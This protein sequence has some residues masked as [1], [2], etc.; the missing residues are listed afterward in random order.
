MW[1]TIQGHDH[2][3]DRFRLAAM[4]GRLSGT[5]LLVGP[6]GVGKRSMAVQL[7]K[8]ILCLQQD[9]EQSLNACNACES[10]RLLDSGNHPD[11]HT[12]TK[13]NDRQLVTIDL[14]VGDQNHRNREGLLV[15]MAYKPALSSRKIAMIDDADLFNIESANTLLKTLEEPPPGAIIFLIGTSQNRQ[16]PT[17]R[18]RSQVIRFGRLAD[19]LVADLL[20]SKG[21][22]SDPTRAKELASA[23]YGSISRAIQLADEELW[24]FRAHL[25]QCLVAPGIDRLRVAR[26]AAKFVDGAGTETY[27]R[28][29]RLQQIV[30]FAIDFYRGILRSQSGADP[31][32]DSLLRQAIARS[33]TDATG[34]DDTLRRLDCCLEMLTYI[35]RN[36]NLA[37]LIEWWIDALA[38]P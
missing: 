12:I 28:R 36:V 30:H 20:I 23:S 37:T 38:R 18:S 9:S 15:D 17:I 29:V 21:I 3:I 22:I 32:G 24:Q 2:V 8:A 27:V 19:D 35:S 25:F 10:C 1:Q 6:E 26:A 33:Q 16:L 34:P 13:R 14:L 5:Y 11:F 4:R 7:A 31:E